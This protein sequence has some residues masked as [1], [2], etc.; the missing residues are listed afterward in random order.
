MDEILKISNNFFSEHQGLVLG[1]VT[2]SILHSSCEAILLP[3]AIANVFNN[4][5]DMEKFPRYLLYLI[6]IWM[7]IKIFYISAN[8]FRKLIEPAITQYIT[9]LLVNAVFQK[10]QY[11]NEIT[12]IS[13]LI[14][15]IQVIKKTLQEIF[16]MSFT[17]FLPRIVV[18]IISVITFLFVNKWLS[19]AIFMGIIFQGFATFY[20]VDK[21]INASFDEFDKKDIFYEYLEDVFYNLPTII[22]IPNGINMETEKLSTFSENVKNIEEEAIDCITTKQNYSYATNIFVFAIIILT[23]YVLYKSKQIELDQ[24]VFSILILSSLFDNMYEISFYIP[25]LISRIGIIK[26]NELFLKNLFRYETSEKLNKLQ[27]LTVETYNIR[28]QNVSFQYDD[29]HKILD[30]FSVN[31]DENKITCLFGPSGSGKTT[32]VK[33]LFGTLEPNTGKVL[34]DCKVKTEKCKEDENKIEIVD[35]DTN[36][37]YKDINLYSLTAL[38]K[39]I[40]YSNQNTSTLFNMTILE[41]L[42]YGF[43]AKDHPSLITK[44]K[45]NFNKFG[46][47]DVFQNLEENGVKFSFLNIKVGKLGEKLSGGQK[48]LIHLLRLDLNQEAKLI[49]LDEPSS[50]LDEVTRDKV[51][52]YIRYLNGQNVLNDQNTNLTKRTVIVITHDPKYQTIANK[53]LTFSNNQNPVVN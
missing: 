9:K 3:K 44:I 46:F 34:I 38:R 6:I 7:F 52:M 47:Y 27:D 50:A 10:Y 36:L 30:N 42:L 15:K 33:L 28:F 45:D 17:L 24:I 8:Q 35:P 20:G 53:I 23:I 29:T 25:E 49:I 22:S 2:F 1:S 16:Y 43:E 19:I 11:E 39:Y 32:L 14:N 51:L 12:N 18:L 40:A 48:Q 41:N 5:K 31:L 13:V 21:C 37:T 26:N 4:V